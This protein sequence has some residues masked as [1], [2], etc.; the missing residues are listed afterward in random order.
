MLT[1][2]LEP[3]AADP[4]V[5]PSRAKV[6]VP[7]GDALPVLA[8]VTVADTVKEAPAGGVVVDGDTVVDVAIRLVTVICAVGEVEP[9]KLPSPAYTATRLCVPEVGVVMLMLTVVPDAPVEPTVVPS[10]LKVTVPEG[11]DEVEAKGVMVAVSCNELPATGVVVAGATA[12]EVAT[13]ATVML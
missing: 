3:S 5:D 11:E 1:V 7:D 13:L 6:T 8:G 2:V 12:R 9:L 10:M 4:T